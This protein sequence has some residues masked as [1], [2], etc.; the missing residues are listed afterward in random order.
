MA[1]LF[2]AGL[3]VVLGSLLVTGSAPDPA[4]AN[5]DV[6]GIDEA[7]ALPEDVEVLDS[8]I[9]L[10]SL[11]ATEAYAED[12]ISV[13]VRTTTLNVRATPSTRGQV[14]GR[15]RRGDVVS[16][17]ARTGA[18][19]QISFG[20]RTAYIYAPYT[21]AAGNATPTPVPTVQPG[22]QLVRVTS[23]TLNV[24][25]GPGT[26]Y[27]AFATLRRG[28]EVR[29]TGQSSGW[30]RIAV[31]GRTGYISASYTQ[32]VAAGGKPTATA[33]P[34]PRLIAT[35]T[36]TPVSNPPLSSG[37]ELGGHVFDTNYFPRMRSI[38]MTWAKVQVVFNGNAPDISG[39]VNAAHS[40]GVKL[41]I[42][43]VGD[44]SRASQ[45]AYHREFA[46]QLANMARQGADAIEVWN[47]PNLDREYV[48]S[49]TGQVNPENYVNM[50]REA[51]AAIKAA[52]SGTLVISAAP[53]PTGYFGGGC[54]AAGCDDAPFVQRMNAAGAT[55]YMDCA[56]AHHNGT[57]VGPDQRTGAPVGS[58]GH[59]QWYF[60]GTL[61]TVYNAF[62]GRVPV[63][64][65][66]L[67]YVTGE[68][69]GPLPSGFSWG[70]NITLANHASWLAR[71]AELSKNSGKVRIM[72]IWN[73]DARQWNDDPQSGFSIFR[74]N[75]SCP[76]CEPLRA[77]MAK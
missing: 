38:G 11:I 40:Q 77:V 63:C 42:G 2:N 6:Q 22:S 49:N 64:W 75:G 53:A 41:L 58:A 29:V 65:T 28:Q 56:G 74:P 15:L 37:F 36:P 60:W 31:N 8:E 72:I 21:A 26:N 76:A 45:T 10:A 55:R 13:V 46:A 54:S 5:Y 12:A 32:V 52:R 70:N 25:N 59:H 71:A 68:G 57:M 35:P 51:H 66:E 44:R 50:L 73:V 27:A 34:A 43:A 33:T 24:R 47:E 9:E 19:W 1:R 4:E 39:L 23:A 48:G 7:Q 3:A 16:A 20:G 69:I 30:Y 14:I 67:G 61:D 17:L 18:W 62:G